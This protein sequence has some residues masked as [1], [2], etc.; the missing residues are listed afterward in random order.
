MKFTAF[1]YV[2]VAFAASGT[3]SPAGTSTIIS[4][5][6]F[7]YWLATT[8]A[9]LTFVGSR[10]D[11]SPLARRSAQTTALTYCNKRIGTLCGGSCT[12]YMGGATC[13]NAPNT[14]CIAATKDVGFCDA[15][16]CNGNCG[17][18]STCGTQLPGGFCAV[19]GTQ[20]IVVSPL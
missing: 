12:V 2:V 6:E 8:D 18:L 7:A 10:P 15:S 1:F 3:A 20:S 13:I 9:E 4:E 17:L 14:A 11:F 19:D 5:A 16:G